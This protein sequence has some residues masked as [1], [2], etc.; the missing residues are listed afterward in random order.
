MR[1]KLVE[2]FRIIL[3]HRYTFEG[4]SR[5]RSLCAMPCSFEVVSTFC[6]VRATEGR[7]QLSEGVLDEARSWTPPRTSL[8]KALCGL[9]RVGGG[10]GWRCG[11]RLGSSTLTS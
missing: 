9:M 8:C 2:H 6:F 10:E 11:A 3:V 4:A 1:G 7:L 5:F